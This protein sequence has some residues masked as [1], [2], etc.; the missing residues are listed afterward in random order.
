MLFLVHT[1][2]KPG[3]LDIR[4]ATREAHLAWL[5]AAGSAIKAAGP[6]LGSDDKPAGSLLIVEMAD[7]A[8]LDA[9][10]AQDPY[11]LAGLFQS[12]EAAP[13]KWV[14]SPPADLAS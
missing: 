14:F 13:Y 11:A 12:V 5:K 3:A 2:D 7:R 8:A 10:L 4:L 1:R 9:W 6:W